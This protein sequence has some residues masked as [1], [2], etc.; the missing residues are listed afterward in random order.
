MFLVWFQQKQA[1]KK[2]KR[3]KK[4][5]F[6]T[7]FQILWKKWFSWFS[8]PSR[9]GYK[10]RTWRFSNHLW[11]F[12]VWITSLRKKNVLSFFVSIIHCQKKF[13][14]TN[15]SNY[16]FTKKHFDFVKVLL[17]FCFGTYIK[18]TFLKKKSFHCK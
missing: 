15:E 4:H 11:S 5:K 10:L 18:T 17:P 6:S 16:V 7:K 14:E 9:P 13:L 1:K 2:K 3:L 8:Y 12:V